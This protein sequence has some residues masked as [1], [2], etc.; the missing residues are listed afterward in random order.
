MFL[1]VLG[2]IHTDYAVLVPKHGLPQGA[3]Q[4]RFAHARGPQED[5]GADGPLR[6]LQSRP[7]P[8]D[9]PA[10]GADR[11][12]LAN[13]PLMEHLLQMQ[14][15]V[16]LALG[17]LL[18]GNTRP[19]GHNLR[20]VVLGHHVLG[21]ALGLLPGRALFLDFLEQRALLVP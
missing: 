15:P 11:L 1:H 21:R 20:D 9:G 5:K 8:A 19:A 4:F 14:Q 12:I 2:H 3:A 13:H 17:H 7:C 10:Y 18:H 16:R 6:V